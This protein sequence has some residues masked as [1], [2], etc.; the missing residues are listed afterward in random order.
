MKRSQKWFRSAL[1]AA[2]A[3]SVLVGLTSVA[4]A[5][6]LGLAPP[7]PADLNI[8]RTLVQDLI[9]PPVVSFTPFCNVSG[10]RCFLRPHCCLPVLCLAAPDCVIT[11]RVEEV[12]GYIV[13]AGDLYCG[14]QELSPEQLL[15]DLVAD[16]FPAPDLV[17]HAGPLTDVARAYLDRLECSATPLS[18]PL[19]AALRAVM[20]SAGF[21]GAFAELDVRQ[22]RLVPRRDSGVIK[23]PGNDWDGITIGDL[24]FLPNATFDALM[25]WQADPNCLTAA[26]QE[27]LSVLVHELVHVRQYRE[28]GRD[29]FLN[30]YL[31]DVLQH[32]YQSA[33]FELE[34]YAVG[35]R[36]NAVWSGPNYSRCL[37]LN[38]V[39]IMSSANAPSGSVQQSGSYGSTYDAWKAFD[40]DPSS[41][42]LSAL[43]AAP[44]TIGYQ[45]ANGPREIRRYALSF[46]NGALTSRA[47]KDWTLQGNNGAG[48]VVLDRRQ[49]QSN[50]RGV[51]RR[52]Y[53]VASPGAY[54]A[55]RFS[56]TDDND[57]RA[58]IV[59]ISL[60]G[61]ELF[62][63]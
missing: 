16:R 10:A 56:F 12:A 9:I 2:S 22:A 11:K 45:W 21:D 60:G 34:A 23:L 36:L 55:Y 18:P 28:L 57:A 44:A 27:P 50:W 43:N 42:W 52:E 51:E 7:A 4:H 24:I 14:L 17:N 8:C 37:M 29:G 39:P 31:I 30:A 48:W 49:G 63:Q 35:D 41:Q 53:S 25:A 38:A 47:P 59:V 61:I 1:T 32:T 54:S 62:R 13:H 20:G 58:G 46:A 26:E 5:S 6:C 40:A 33:E 19:I 15:S 3:A